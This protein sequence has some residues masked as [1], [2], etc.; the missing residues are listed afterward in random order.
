[1]KTVR[2]ALVLAACA[3]MLVC[4]T[5]AGTLAYLTA[6]KTVTNTFTVGNVDIT[7]DEAPVGKNGKKTDGSR[8]QTNEYKLLPGQDYD[9]D[10]TITVTAKSEDCYVFVT[11]NNEISDVEDQAPG[12]TIE[13]QM[14]A[15]GTWTELEDGVYYYTGTEVNEKGVIP[16]SESAT[17]LEPVFEH[18]YV[19]PDATNEA[20]N[21]IVDGT[22]KATIVVNA[23]A[24]QAEGFD[25]VSDA[26]AAIEAQA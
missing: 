15:N 20:L 4:A 22:G 21:A 26:W 13:D 3:I 16:Y 18:F 6:Q 8:V 14:T 24:I 9:K 2:K 7:M 23:Y 25:N 10:P 19:S 1:M 17:K 5:I 11:I 12:K